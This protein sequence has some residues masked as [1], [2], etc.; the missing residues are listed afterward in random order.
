M[1]GDLPDPERWCDLPA[2]GRTAEHAI[3]AALR[4]VKDATEP[5]AGAAA[6]L[7]RRIDEPARWWSLEVAWR[8]VVIALLIMAT[9]SAVGAALHKWWLTGG[10]GRAMEPA[11]RAPASA[12]ASDREARRGRHARVLAVEPPA[13]ATPETPPATPVE[14]E[15]PPAPSP[16]RQAARPAAVVTPPPPPPPSEAGVLAGAFHEL[17]SSGDARAALR[18]L[19]DY[20]RRFPTGALR[21]ES[22]IARAEA[23]LALD[24]RR[25][26]LPLLDGLEATGAALTRDVR[27]ARGELLAEAGRCPE[28]VGDFD[29]VLAASAGD[30]SGGR[31]LYGRA[32]CRLRDGD[33]ARARQDLERYLL[34]HPDGPFAAAARHAVGSAP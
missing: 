8:V 13:P 23:L 22:R 6:R 4:R 10:G 9:G 26:A 29:A 31:A 14:V 34:V 32:S 2:R 5:P 11:T 27:V 33:R 28:A 7:S 12:P 30:A 16:H 18:A 19:D 3:G 21:G 24:R 20:D 17:R 1:K 15:P 25:E